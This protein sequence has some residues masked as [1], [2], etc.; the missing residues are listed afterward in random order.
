[1]QF[2]TSGCTKS[3]AEMSRGAYAFTCKGCRQAARL[4]GELRDLRQM[5]D[6]LERMITGQGLENESGETGDQVARREETEEKEKCEPVMTPGS[7][8]T[9]ES[10]KGKETAERSSSEDRGTDIEMDGENGTEEGETGRQLLDGKG[11]RP[12]TQMLATQL[13]EPEW[14]SGKR[15]GFGG[16]RYVSLLDGAR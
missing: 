13:Q 14:S 8:L 6:S 15:A 7:I 9:E 5:M 2:D 11:L 4:V 10:W 3:W 1:M 16:R 12:G